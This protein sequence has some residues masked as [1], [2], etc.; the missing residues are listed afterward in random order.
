MG[1]LYLHLYQCLQNQLTKEIRDFRN[2]ELEKDE[3]VNRILQHLENPEG[4]KR[5]KRKPKRQKTESP[6]EPKEA[7]E[8]KE[9]PKDPESELEPSEADNYSEICSLKSR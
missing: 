4:K 1:N 8:T 2:R 9:G 7:G 6:P 5:K 3:E